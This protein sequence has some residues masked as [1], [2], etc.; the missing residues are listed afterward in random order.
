MVWEDELL[1]PEEGGWGRRRGAGKRKLSYKTSKSPS[2]PRQANDTAA[3]KLSACA[4][5]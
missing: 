5:V 1:D 2:S 4:E 3:P